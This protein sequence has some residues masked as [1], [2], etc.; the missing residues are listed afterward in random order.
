MRNDDSDRLQGSRR[1]DSDRSK[2]R[3]TILVWLTDAYFFTEMDYHNRPL[4]LRTGDFILVAKP[5]GGFGVSDD[6]VEQARIGVGQIG[7]LMGALNTRQMWTYLTPDERE[8]RRRARR[9]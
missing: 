2:Q 1:V 7:K 3:D 9:A 5:E 8:E 6:L 4:V